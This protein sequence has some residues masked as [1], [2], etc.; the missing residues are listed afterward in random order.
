M[1]LTASTRLIDAEETGVSSIE[2]ILREFRAG[3][4]VILVDDEGR[5]NEGDLVVAAQCITPEHINFMASFARGLIC[6]TLTEE[7]C[8]QLNL[9][10]MVH[11]N[12]ARY[13]TNF[14]VSIEAAEGVTTTAAAAEATTTPLTAGLSAFVSVPGAL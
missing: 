11:N 6:L 3:R 13:S 2:E 14:T 8:R 9:P 5:E 12:N 7:R 10:L 4:F 1:E